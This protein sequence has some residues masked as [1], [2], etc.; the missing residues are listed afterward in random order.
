MEIGVKK[1]EKEKIE[2]EQPKKPE[3]EIKGKPCKKAK[4]SA[5]QLF[6]ESFIADEIGDLKEYIVKDLVVPMIKDSICD[7]ISNTLSMML[8]GEKRDYRRSSRYDYGRSRSG[9]RYYDY[10]SQRYSS[11]RD[12]DRR[13]REREERRY[14]SPASFDMAVAQNM[15]DAKDILEE[16]ADIFDTYEC[17]SIAQYHQACE[18]PTT[19]EEHNWGW[20]SLVDVRLKEDRATGEVLIW[21]PRAVSLK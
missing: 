13:D 17:V 20:Y 7:G 2:E 6:K 12:R 1:L 16:L 9:V 18:L 8:Y 4:K 5:F 10:S 19:P 21:M 3:K 11:S 15:E 14:A